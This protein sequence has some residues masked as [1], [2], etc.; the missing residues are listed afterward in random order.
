MDKE[1]RTPDGQQIVNKAAKQL[2]HKRRFDAA[3]YSS[4]LQNWVTDSIHDFDEQLRIDL[5]TLRS[6]ARDAAINDVYARSY[7][8]AL[9]T[10]VVGQD[11]IVGKFNVRFLNGKIDTFSNEKL[12]ELWNTWTKSV[13]TDGLNM[14]EMQKLIIETVARDGEIF[15]VM[16][17]GDRFGPHKLELQCF[18]P[19]YCDH[20]YN[21]LAENGNTIRSGIEYDEFG[22]ITAYYLYKYHPKAITRSNMRR[23]NERIRFP[24]K[25]VLHIFAKERVTQGRGFPWVSS[26]LVNLTHLREYQKSELVASRVASA[27]MGFYTRP[28]GEE[29]Y[30]GDGEDELDQNSFFQEAEAGMFDILP[31]GYSVETFDPQNPNGN[32]NNFV[33]KVLQ[34]VASSLGIAYHTLSN[35]LESTSYSSLRQG[36]IEERDTFR[37]HQ[38]MMIDQML[39]PVFEIWLGHVLG[40]NIAGP[41]FPVQMFEKFNQILWK[42][43][44][45]QWIDPQKETAA[46][47]LQ[48]EQKIR[49]RSDV[50]R[51][52]GMEYDDVLAEIAEEEALAEKHG[53]KLVAAPT[54]SVNVNAEPDDASGDDD[55]ET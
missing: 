26:A 22:K 37:S 47:K 29:D 8:E 15:V 54:T 45:W 16:R 42:P 27:K 24:A 7:F 6:R 25:D 48:I 17:K 23:K 52:L 51:S 35:D 36:A 12:Q 46:I 55:A 9:K 14:Q 2:K 3:G 21:G 53:V 19:E 38:Q 18:E 5:S 33:K 34:G 40:F 4:F 1:K 28:R 30:L 44:T 31:D 10:N 49:S 11:G 43:R 41:Q 32:F 13:T 20:D 39:Q 50:A